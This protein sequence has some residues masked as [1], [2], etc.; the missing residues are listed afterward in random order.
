MILGISFGL[1]TSI[2]CLIR[3]P[4]IDGMQGLFCILSLIVLIWWLV[5]TIR[6][7]GMWKRYQAGSSVSDDY[8][9]GQVDR[10]YV[11]YFG[12]RHGCVALMLIIQFLMIFPMPIR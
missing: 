3:D 7:N 9:F 2:F 4:L 8:R 10:D 12:V 6:A 5:V 11:N 1:L